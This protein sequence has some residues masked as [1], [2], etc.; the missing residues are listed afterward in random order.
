[1]ATNNKL[2]GWQAIRSLLSLVEREHPVEHA[3]PPRSNSRY[4]PE[5]SM[6]LVGPLENMLMSSI[7]EWC[8][9]AEFAIAK[10]IVAALRYIKINRSQPGDNPFALTQSKEVIIGI[11]ATKHMQFQKQ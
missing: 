9:S 6:M 2:I 5:P 11:Y 1:M 4:T 10:L 3:A 7:A 8:V